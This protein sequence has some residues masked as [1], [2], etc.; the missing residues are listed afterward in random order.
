MRLPWGGHS[1]WDVQTK[2]VQGPHTADEIFYSLTSG[3]VTKRDDAIG[4]IAVYNKKS[5]KTTLYLH[6]RKIIERG[7]DVEVGSI[8]GI[9]GNLGLGY[10]LSDTNSDEHVHIEVQEGRSEKYSC[11]ASIYAR[12]TDLDPINYLYESAI[13]RKWD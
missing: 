10:D 11:G 8:L 13:E 9:Q 6:A 7:E 3:K 12:R 4:L 5:N 1:G 2:T